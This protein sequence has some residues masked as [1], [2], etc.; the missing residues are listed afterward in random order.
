MFLIQSGCLEIQTKAD[1]G[2]VFAIERLY[3]GSI[4]NH[5]S[6]LLKDEMD[7]DALC[8]TRVFAY[9]IHIDVVN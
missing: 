8:V 5:N 2:E 1:K 9:C 3:R 7:T 4:V 6:M